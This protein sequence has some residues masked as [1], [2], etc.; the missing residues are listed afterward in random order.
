MF[1]KLLAGTKIHV[2]INKADYPR[3]NVIFV[4]GMGENIHRYDQLT[5]QLLKRNFN[6]IR[7]DQ[8]SHGQSDGNHGDI[9]DLN[10]FTAFSTTVINYVKER[11]FD[12]ATFMM[13]HSMG[14]FATLMTIT[15]YPGL[16]DGAIACSPFSLYHQEMLGPLPVEGDPHAPFSGIKVAGN[17]GV[18]RD[19]RLSIRNGKDHTNVQATNGT[20]N[21]TFEGALFLRDHLQEITDPLFLIHGVEDGLISYRDTMDVF[22]G[23]GTRDRELHIYPF[24]MHATLNDPSRN[25]DIVE[26]V[27]HWITRR[28]Y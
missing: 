28:L 9:E 14:G 27:D 19:S 12:L 26:E 5:A 24:L 16:V 11:F 1:L 20:I 13:G 22:N 6:V 18:H 8:P 15:K 17:G 21:T 7:Y 25:N 2:V 23:V 10:L 4:H 3:D